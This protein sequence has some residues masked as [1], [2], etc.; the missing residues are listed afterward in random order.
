[1]KK[2]EEIISKFLRESLVKTSTTVSLHDERQLL[3]LWL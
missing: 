1:M 2:S 3:S